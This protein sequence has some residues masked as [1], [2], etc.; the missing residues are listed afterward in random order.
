MPSIYI[1]I[2]LAFTI[3]LLEILIYRSHLISSLL[4]LEGIIF[5]LFIINTLTT[6]NIHSALINIMPIAL[7][8]FTT[9]EAAVGLALLV[10]ISSTYGLDYVYNLNL[11]QC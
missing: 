3:S 11:L 1:N 10:S 2:V 7:L 5:S 4:C 6:L 9:C 8:V